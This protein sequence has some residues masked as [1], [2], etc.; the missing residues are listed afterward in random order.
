MGAPVVVGV[1]VK[2]ATEVPDDSRELPDATADDDIEA[3][4]VAL[5]V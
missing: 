5:P 3:E 1:I 4:S 2:L